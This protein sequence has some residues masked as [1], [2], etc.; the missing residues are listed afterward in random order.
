MIYLPSKVN[1]ETLD[2]VIELS[3]SKF[4]TSCLLLLLLLLIE[5][6]LISLDLL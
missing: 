6:E 3:V 5:L 2:A 4:A 1:P